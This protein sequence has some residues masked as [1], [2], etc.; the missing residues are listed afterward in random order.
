[1]SGVDLVQQDDPRVEHRHL[2][3]L[4]SL[5]LPAREVVVHR[6]FEKASHVELL[7]GSSQPGFEFTVVDAPFVRRLSHQVVE[8]DARDLD[9]VLESVHQ[10]HA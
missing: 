1:M 8:S 9:R 3:D 4:G 7:G 2:E 5:L 10:A 6:A